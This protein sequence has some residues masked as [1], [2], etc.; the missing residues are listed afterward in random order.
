MHNTVLGGCVSF[1]TYI[2]LLAYTTVLLTNMVEYKNDRIM[3]KPFKQDTNSTKLS[4][5]R[6]STFNFLIY[7]HP[8]GSMIPVKYD[9][10]AKQY[11]KVIFSQKLFDFEKRLSNLDETVGE[12]ETCTIE[13]FQDKF[14][15]EFRKEE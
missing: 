6:I 7:N 5:M 2:L 9:N 13:H 12:G 1:F 14:S 3:T 8:N 4:E 10:T 15:S 11:I